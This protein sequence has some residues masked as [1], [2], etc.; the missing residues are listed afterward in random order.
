MLHSGKGK[1]YF[2]PT[3]FRINQILC[4]HVLSSLLLFLFLFHSLSAAQ[5]KND[6]KEPIKPPAPEILNEIP[7]KPEKKAPQ[8]LFFNDCEECM[9]DSRQWHYDAAEVKGIIERCGADYMLLRYDRKFVDKDYDII[10][11]FN[12]AY[13]NDRVDLDSIETLQKWNSG[14]MQVR[15]I[16]T[17]LPGAVSIPIP[18]PAALTLSTLRKSR[19]D[20]DAISKLCAG[21]ESKIVKTK[22]AAMGYRLYFRQGKKAWL[23]GEMDIVSAEWPW[24]E[25][26][27]QKSL[28]A[29]MVGYAGE[30]PLAEGTCF[31]EQQGD[32]VVK[33]LLVD[34]PLNQ[35]RISFEI[36][37]GSPLK[38][39]TFSSSHT[40]DS[41]ALSGE[42]SV[43][44]SKIISV[45]TASR[46]VLLEISDI[47]G[48][49]ALRRIAV[50][51]KL[52]EYKARQDTARRL[53][54]IK[55]SLATRNVGFRIVNF[56]SK[57]DGN[58]FT[59]LI[60]DYCDNVARSVIRK[61][62]NDTLKK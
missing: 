2:T 42:K 14:D 39:A 24:K 21:F 15:T 37:S 27:A 48:K 18:A 61:S 60:H 22:D 10:S 35:C 17:T 19:I 9:K 51:D 4:F 59:P 20:V 29:F 8:R 53:L 58:L 28:V 7:I 34:Y 45:D 54:R 25:S 40:I 56:A 50:Y 33:N 49:T 52:R 32:I 3:V 47:Y 26:P 44:L 36:A 16:A 31:N 46:H 1:K 55:D 43:R 30:G 11:R 38:K 57:F 6:R 13:R 12:F 5:I 23:A 62:G 41:V